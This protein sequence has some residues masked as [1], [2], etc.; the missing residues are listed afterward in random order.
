MKN[1]KW[2]IIA[3]IM[4]IVLFI[5]GVITNYID[6][7][8]VTTN[9]EPKFCIKTINSEGNKVTYWGLGYKVIRYVGV[10]PDEPYENNIGA[11]L[12]NWFMKYDL[13]EVN[14][15]EIEY[16]G[17]NINVTDI[18][19][20]G[21]IENILLYSK[22]NDELCSGINTHKITLNNEVYYIKED[23]KA[24]QKGNKQAT[25]TKA[26]LNLINNIIANIIENEP[27]KITNVLPNFN[28]P[29]NVVI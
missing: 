19:D 10:S 7:G 27:D 9:H 5:L 2:L 21:I 28:V 24:I 29:V 8:R 13:P 4:V 26:D 1:K 20:I 15:I 17:K 23:C 16:E 12:G 22:Y 11:K 14:A 25:I 3:S 18:K 6:T